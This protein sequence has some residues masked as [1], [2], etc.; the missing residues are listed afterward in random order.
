MGR[1]MLRDV[2]GPTRRIVVVLLG[3]LA[4]V[5]T[6]S[7]ASAGAAVSF[8]VKGKWTCNNRGTVIPIAGAR[9]ELWRDISFWPDDMLGP[10]H[11]GSDGSFSFS[12]S[13]DSNF[14]LYVKLILKD[15]AGVHLGNWYSFSDW[16]TDT[17]TT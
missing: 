15:D 1:G 11:T 3:V 8:Q 5:L 7:P 13:A 10:A 16:D 4:L 17:S 14:D 2:F 9:V 6:A 12:V